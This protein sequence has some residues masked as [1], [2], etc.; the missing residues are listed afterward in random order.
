[1]REHGE[2]RLPDTTSDGRPH[3]SAGEVYVPGDFAADTFADGMP[4]NQAT[5]RRVE[6]L[7]AADEAFVDAHYAIWHHPFE[8]EG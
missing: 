6:E 8:L 4:F 1:M 5:R 2:V 3:P 7:L